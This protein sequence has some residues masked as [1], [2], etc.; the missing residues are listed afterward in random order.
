MTATHTGRKLILFW[1]VE[2]DPQTEELH[3]LTCFDLDELEAAVG[4]LKRLAAELPKASGGR[5]ASVE[6]RVE[7]P[8]PLWE[9]G[10]LEEPILESRPPDE[11]LDDLASASVV[12]E[13][14]AEAVRRE[15]E[16]RDAFYGGPG[17]VR[18]RAVL[19]GEAERL[20]QGRVYLEAEHHRGDFTGFVPLGLL[21]PEG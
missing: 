6:L 2:E 17:Y 11:A 15:L 7:L 14:E 18:W 9:Y 10:F 8:P 13:E 5:K 3:F 20:S 4:E 1:T 21:L 12:G 16:G 19:A